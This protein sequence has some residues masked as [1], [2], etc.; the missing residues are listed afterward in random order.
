MEVFIGEDRWT[1]GREGKGTAR[2][3]EYREK[4]QRSHIQYPAP[5][6]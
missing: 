4:G 5:F 1:R 6:L 3:K 2:T